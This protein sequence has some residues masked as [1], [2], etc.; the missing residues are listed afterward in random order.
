M[1]VLVIEDE[2]K[3]LNFVKMGLTSA[4]FTVDTARDLDEAFSNMLSVNYD[5][6]VLDRLLKGVDS[7][8]HIPKI[9]KKLPNTK[10][11]ILSALSEVDD[12]VDGLTIGADDY[13]TKPFHISELIARIRSLGRRKDELLSK[14][15]I[16]KY[17]D[18]VIKLDSQ[19][20]E[21]GGKKIE[22][23]SKE[24]KLLLKLMRR[25]NRIFSK[26]ELI[27]DVWE[28]DFY[29]ESNVVEVVINHLR[30]KLDR[31]FDKEFIHS[32]RGVGYWFGDKD[33]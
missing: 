22:L 33:L 6:I 15:N 1:K 9:K 24:Y 31:G 4:E 2:V 21:R 5:V 13:L 25:P 11:I 29:P 20:V 14:D 19:R 16:M 26:T 18:L 12:K 28:L 32:R 8:K 7:I 23:S 3:V 17:K 27:N 10:I 30:N